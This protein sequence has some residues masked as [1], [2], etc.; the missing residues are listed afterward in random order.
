MKDDHA[1]NVS[2]DTFLNRAALPDVPSLFLPRPHDPSHVRWGK[3][4]LLGLLVVA[5][6][7]A[8]AAVTALLKGHHVMGTTSEVS[9][10][11]LIATYVFF[12]ALTSGLCLVSSLGHVFGF[13]VFEPIA[14]KALF[15]AFVT[16][17][18]GFSVIATELERPFL[19]LKLAIVSPNPSAPI[20]WMGALYGTYTPIIAAELFFLMREDHRRARV[21]GIIGV[22]AAFAAHSNLGAVFSLA[23]ARPFWFGPFVPLYL[24]ALALMA[25]TAMLILVVYLG[26]YFTNDKRVRPENAAL[27]EVLRQLFGLFIG[28]VALFTFWRIVNGVNGAHYHVYEVT[29]ASLAGP[30]FFSFWVFEV[31][32]GLVA[33]L[34]LVLTKAKQSFGAL[35]FAAA[36]PTVAIFV[37]RFNFVMNGQMF[38]LKPVVG[39]DGARLIYQPPFKGN[40]EGFLAYTPSIVESLIVL[41]AL[42]AAALLYV[43]GQKIL[44]VNPEAR[45]V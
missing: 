40:V 5:L 31:F 42:A 38:S 21:V 25:G 1:M 11:V 18:V 35:A 37:M 15:L 45:H 19:L 34:T 2:L 8:A 26:D 24:V 39:H 4:L 27:L 12:V 44:R 3:R 43:G 6:A 14:K 22:V 13:K 16:L 9:W 23:H 30:L 36:L 32:L 20:W 17:V 33:P 29:L 7:G 28:L 41:G 10:G